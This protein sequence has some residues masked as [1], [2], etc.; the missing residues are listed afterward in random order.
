MLLPSTNEIKLEFNTEFV[1]KVMEF[2]KVHFCSN[3]LR[4]YKQILGFDVPVNDVITMAVL[5]RL[6]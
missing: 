4:I 6:Q 2:T 1:M 5:D 3:F